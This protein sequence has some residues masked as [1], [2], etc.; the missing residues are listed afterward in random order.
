MRHRSGPWRPTAQYSVVGSSYSGLVKWPRG[1]QTIDFYID[2]GKLE[3]IADDQLDVFAFEQLEQADARLGTARDAL[4]RGKDLG[5]ALSAAYDAFRIA[6]DALLA[7]QGLR[8]S[9]GDGSHVT[10][11]DSAAAQFDDEIPDFSVAGSENFRTRRH[12]S[13]YREIGVPEVTRDDASWAVEKAEHAVAGARNLMETN[14][15]SYYAD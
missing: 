7:R 2:R 5:G 10:V 6:A 4:A 12:R 1:Q 9:G 13:Q 15:P 14:P 8:A 3:L 11:L